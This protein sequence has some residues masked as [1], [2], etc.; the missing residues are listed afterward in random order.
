MSTRNGS[1]CI[2]LRLLAS[3]PHFPISSSQTA[4]AVYANPRSVAPPQHLERRPHESGAGDATG[5]VRA[6][7]PPT[8]SLRVVRKLGHLVPVDVDGEQR[9]ALVPRE[10]TAVAEVARVAEQ[11]HDGCEVFIDHRSGGSAT[12]ATR[13]SASRARSGWRTGRAGGSGTRSWRARLHHEQAT[14][15]HHEQSDRQQPGDRPTY[16]QQPDQAGQQDS[17]TQPQDS[18][19]LCA[20]EMTGRWCRSHRCHRR[21]DNRQ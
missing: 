3:P 4:P 16:R 20:A 9:F 15:E 21:L 14:D 19:S 12:S 2:A 13:R 18:P 1:T 8:R 7:H 6:A 11:R 5:D 10:V 17:S